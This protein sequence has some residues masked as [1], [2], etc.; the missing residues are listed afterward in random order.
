MQL[1]GRFGKQGIRLFLKVMEANLDYYLYLIRFRVAW[2]F[3]H[4]G[5]G[6]SNPITIIVENLQ[7]CRV[8]VKVKRN[9]I[10][11]AQL[12]TNDFTFNVDGSV[13]VELGTAG[14]GG[15]LCN[16]KGEVLCSFSAYVGNLDATTNE[17]LAI[18]KACNLCQSKSVLNEGIS[19]L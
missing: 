9:K 11:V 1:C 14:I 3:K 2:W 8:D 5:K 4:C 17:L 6:S 16:T 19:S 15:I 13:R 12:P 18:L 10:K 7:T